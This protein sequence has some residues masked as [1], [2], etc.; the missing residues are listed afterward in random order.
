MNTFKNNSAL[1]V[2]DLQ[3]DFLPPDGSLAV[4]NG[5]NV[6][7]PILR[8]LDVSKY[9]WK[10][11]VAT[12]DWHPVNHCSFASQH[13]VPP[14]T[15]KNFR[16]PLKQKDES[17][18]ILSSVQ[19]VWPDHCVQGSK[20]SEIDPQFMRYFEEL[21]LYNINTEIIQKGYIA[22]QEYYSCFEDIWGVHKTDINHFLRKRGI[23]SLYFVGLAYDFCVLL[24]AIDS[25]KYGFDTFIIKD[26]SESVFPDK[27]EDTEAKLTSFG[28]KIITSDQ[29]LDTC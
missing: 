5:R 26:C 11:V 25:V 10:A 2:V 22:E 17:G 3:E 14:F 9:K 13:A 18:K 27:K 1:V 16:H 21:K 4:Q 7:L 23:T 15:Q 20:G 24:S 29:L 6:I 12:Q 8:L 19:T 28:V